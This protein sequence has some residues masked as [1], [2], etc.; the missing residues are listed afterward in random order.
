MVEKIEPE[1]KLCVDCKHFKDPYCQRPHLDS[2]VYPDG[3]PRT[4]L[5]AIER[6]TTVV[7]RGKSIRRCGPDG[8]LWVKREEVEEKSLLRRAWELI[9]G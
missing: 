1:T 4:V 8:C 9:R 6:N 7:S 5:A 3:S 2:L